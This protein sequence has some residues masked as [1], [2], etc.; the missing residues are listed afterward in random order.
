[1]CSL[2]TLQLIPDATATEF[3]SHV[4]RGASNPLHET[5]KYQIK[6]LVYLCVKCE[7]QQI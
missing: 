5:S 3:L 6:T 4:K 7:R 2:S 1:M